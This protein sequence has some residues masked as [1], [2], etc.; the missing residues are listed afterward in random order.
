MSTGGPRTLQAVTSFLGRQKLEHSSVEEQYCDKLTV[1]SGSQIAYVSV[2]NSGKIVIGGKDSPLK[3]LLEEMKRA[4]EAGEAVPGQALPF[5]IDRFPETIRERVPDCD[6]II[7][8]FIEEAIRCVRADALLASA[9]MIGA[10]SEKAISLLIQTFGDSIV[11]QTNRERFFSKVNN[12]AISKKYEEFLASYN[13]CHSKPTEP[14]LSQDLDIIIGSMFQFCR[15]T[16]NE[17]G[18]PQIVPDLDRGVILANLAHFI[19]Y[20]ERIYAL[21]R[22]FRD[23]GVV[24]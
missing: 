10:A 12:R 20:I 17:V 23:N 6:P 11:D 24:L 13:G 19:T 18:H 3:S 21:M 16:R 5:E 7:V 8:R 2:Y 14:V 22:H 9:F 1:R 15:I 4:I